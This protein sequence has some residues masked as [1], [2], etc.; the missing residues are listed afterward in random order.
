MNPARSF[1]SALVRG[2]WKKHYVYWIGPGLGS[3]FSAVVYGLVLATPDKLWIP[4]REPV[5]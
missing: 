2:Y 1:G 4:V 3:I 5:N